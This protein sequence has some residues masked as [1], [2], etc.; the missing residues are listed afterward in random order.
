MKIRDF[1]AI[2][3]VLGATGIA[4]GASAEDDLFDLTGFD[5]DLPEAEE[6]AAITMAMERSAL[7]EQA[8]LVQ[9][10]RDKIE[11]DRL[12]KKL[13][14]AVQNARRGG[15]TMARVQDLI[16]RGADVT[17]RDERGYIPLHV[18]L[19]DCAI[20]EEVV[21]ALI[22]KSPGSIN[23]KAGNGRTPLHIALLNAQKK[24]I[25]KAL[26]SAGA[27]LDIPDNVGE[28][29]RQLARISGIG[30]W[31]PMSAR[32]RNKLN[33]KLFRAVQDVRR[34]EGT[35]ARVQDL[36]KRGA[37][38]TVPDQ[39]GWIPLHL[40]ST[41]MPGS[42]EKLSEELIKVL[43]KANPSSVNYITLNRITSEGF[44]PLRV[45]VASKSGEE[46][47]IVKALLSAGALPNIPDNRGVTPLCMAA[48][49][50]S[51][52]ELGI[53]KALLSAG[54]DPNISNDEGATPLQLAAFLESE[55]KLEVVIALLKA[56]ANPD[57]RDIQGFTSLHRAI[58]CDEND[59]IV[60]VLLNA[61]A[62]LDIPNYVG[63]TPRQLIIEYGDEYLLPM[64]AREQ[65]ELNDVFEPEE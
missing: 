56:G 48:S 45:A 59:E 55:D 10:Q 19:L 62:N 9:R 6:V 4:Y 7:A 3:L 42:H 2:S 61:G 47:G 34:G 26:L 24:E 20:P 30:H 1:L 12:N 18:A 14:R 54:A 44:T 29:P 50:R 16:D 65:E 37:D 33:E 46:L 23:H 41:G 11:Q 8:E 52:E 15:D 60:K 51:R 35:V 36:I 53:V 64:S 58:L 32:E 40:A 39:N 38:V 17:A 28:T 5:A 31:L 43:T 22:R 27:D 63:K 49:L 13:F 57:I 25:I 21:A